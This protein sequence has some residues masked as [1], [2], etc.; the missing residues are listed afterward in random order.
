MKMHHYYVYL[1]MDVCQLRILTKVT[2]Y[3]YSSG[4]YCPSF[5]PLVEEYLFFFVSLLY[6]IRYNLST[7]YSTLLYLSEFSD[8]SKQFKVLFVH[9]KRPHLLISR[10]DA[11]SVDLWKSD[12]RI[13]VGDRLDDRSRLFDPG[14]LLLDHD[15]NGLRHTVKVLGPKAAGRGCGRSETDAGRHER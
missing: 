1:N 2:Y 5:L 15:G 13:F 11:A 7:I 4:V 12:Q 14:F 6:K 3:R 10:Q 9:N 8:E